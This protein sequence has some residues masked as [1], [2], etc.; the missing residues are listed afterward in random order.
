M[1]DGLDFIAVRV[2]AAWLTVAVDGAIADV[3][4]DQ[5]KPFCLL[6]SPHDVYLGGIEPDVIAPVDLADV[7]HL[8]L[9]LAHHRERVD[10][11]AGVLDAACT[12]SC[13]GISGGQ[14][15]LTGVVRRVDGDLVL[16]GELGQ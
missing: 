16:D 2:E 13:V 4:A 8:G 6:G 7:E 9:V 1:F 15:A 5:P 14:G 12:A 11:A 10:E 3:D